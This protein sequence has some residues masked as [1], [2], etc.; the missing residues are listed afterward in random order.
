M[1]IFDSR[2]YMVFP[3]PIKK[4]TTGDDKPLLVVDEC[5][6]HNGHS[7]IDKKA[8]FNGLRGIVI[9][10]KNNNITGLVALSPV[11]G[12][13]SRISFDTKL[14]KDEIWS[15]HCPVCDEALPIY[16]TCCCGADMITIFSTNKASFTECICICNRID[17]YHAGIVTGNDLIS[18]MHNATQIEHII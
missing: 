7:L 8:L 6:C 10:V 15:I 18:E 4:E 14:K 5:Y 3:A 11:Y 16:S 1:K 2:G 9:R 13:K 12:Y 17:C